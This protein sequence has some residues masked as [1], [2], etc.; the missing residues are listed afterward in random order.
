M[1]TSSY[2]CETK[3]KTYTMTTTKDVKGKTISLG[4]KVIY[5]GNTNGVGLEFGVVKKITDKIVFV[6]GSNS[7]RQITKENCGRMICV[8][9]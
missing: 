9:D 1:E 5:I 3:Q 6:E 8:I 4:N 7:N 2:L